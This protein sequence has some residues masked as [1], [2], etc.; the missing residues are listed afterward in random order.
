MSLYE[1]RARLQKGMYLMYSSSTGSIQAALR[2]LLKNGWIALDDSGDRS[3]GKKVYCLTAAGREHFM[4][5]LSEPV[6]FAN[7]N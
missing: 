3:R 7:S 6:Q 1:I 5:W 2:K 4:R